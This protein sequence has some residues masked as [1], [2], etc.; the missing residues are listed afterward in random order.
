MTLSE[1]FK[2]ISTVVCPQ[3]NEIVQISQK[4]QKEAIGGASRDE[5]PITTFM[6]GDNAAEYMNDF[7]TEEFINKNI[8]VRP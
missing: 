7:A 1:V 2:S 8:R 3:L 6:G 5:D 4:R